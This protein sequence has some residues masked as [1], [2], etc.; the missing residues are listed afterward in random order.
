MGS[1]SRATGLRVPRDS[2]TVARAVEISEGFQPDVALVDL[3]IP[4]TGGL[5]LAEQLTEQN[6]G[7]RII[8]TTGSPNADLQLGDLARKA[9]VDSILSKPLRVAEVLREIKG[10]KRSRKSMA[11]ILII[12]DEESNRMPLRDVLRHQGHEIVEAADGEEGI[13]QFRK[14]KPD[15]VITDLVM[16][17]QFAQVADEDRECEC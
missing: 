12:D 1:P 3:I 10:R 17:V 4:E 14:S 2:D 7:I 16:D 8:L 11:K 13:Q 9:G 5:D 15:L 6:P